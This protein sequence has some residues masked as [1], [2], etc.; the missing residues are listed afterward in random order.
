MRIAA[1]WRARTDKT[2]TLV[3][4][5]NATGKALLR[6]FGRIPSTLTISPTYNGYTL[7]AIT[8]TITFIR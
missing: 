7:A 3:M 5:L 8:R 4:R 6:K 1:A 2:L